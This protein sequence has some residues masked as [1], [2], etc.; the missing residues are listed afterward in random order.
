MK[1]V[2]QPK[3]ES[4]A[5]SEAPYLRDSARFVVVV[6]LPILVTIKRL[7]DVLE[8]HGDRLPDDLRQAYR[9]LVAAFDVPGCHL[10]HREQLF[11]TQHPAL[12]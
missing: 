11:P 6:P 12:Q 3:R 1:Q 7:S 4:Q 9:D 5:R 10:L 2:T 8:A